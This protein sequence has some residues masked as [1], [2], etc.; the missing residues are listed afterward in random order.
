[1]SFENI[2]KIAIVGRTPINV[3]A[4]MTAE[5]V[6]STMNIN[7]SDFTSSVDGDTLNLVAASGSKGLIDVVIRD[8]KVYPKGNVVSFPTDADIELISELFPDDNLFETLN[9]PVK[10]NEYLAKIEETQEAR[11]EGE[12]AG[13]KAERA[14]VIT[15]VVT[16][17]N[18]LKPYMVS[19]DSEIG[20]LAFEIVK[21]QVETLK[22]FVELAEAEKVAKL[23]EE[24]LAAE[25][26]ELYA[27]VR[28]EGEAN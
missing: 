4:S 26:E 14:E 20:E 25:L 23:Q 21:D 12:F 27:Q 2:R 6:L 3:P 19:F 10:L 15:E 7:V 9:S 16:T 5:Q 24:A 17:I 8:G 13:L 28:A 18:K 22:N 1:M 11:L